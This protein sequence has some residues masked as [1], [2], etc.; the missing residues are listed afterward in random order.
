MFQN[1]INI[2]T[3]PQSAFTFLREK[4]SALF[5]LLLI[6]VM[7]GLVQILYVTNVDPD[8]LIEQTIEQ[9]QA[10]INIPED[11]LRENLENANPTAQ[12]IQSA[13]FI[14]II[15]PIIYSIF[16]GYL[17][18]MSKFS[19]DEIGF[20]HWFSLTCWTG[21]VTIFA[22]LASIVVILT[23]TDGLITQSQLQAL[24][25]NNLIFQ[26]TGSFK[27]M[28][29]SI[30]LTQIWSLVLLILGFKAWTGKSTLGSTLIVAAPYVLIFGTWSLIIIL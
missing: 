17:T 11:Q 21:V 8:F 10:F 22:A 2:I 19:G 20:K 3:A 4:R 25:L 6:I 5:P 24:S 1:F 27:T 23:S 18:F 30:D 7:T 26:S 16:A 14:A 9:A 28:L 13:I 12:G 29:S 15:L